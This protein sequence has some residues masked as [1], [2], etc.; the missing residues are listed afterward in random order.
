M[1]GRQKPGSGQAEEEGG[2]PDGHADEVQEM[3]HAS[4][5]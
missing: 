5:A 3:P 4:G 1:G 2:D